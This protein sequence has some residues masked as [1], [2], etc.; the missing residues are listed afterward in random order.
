MNKFTKL[1]SYGQLIVVTVN[2]IEFSITSERLKRLNESLHPVRMR[3]WS[4]FTVAVILLRAQFIFFSDVPD[5]MLQTKICLNLIVRI[6]VEQRVSWPGY[7]H[8][9]E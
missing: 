5:K 6:C 1:K 8:R 4:V 9:G 2:I 7:A 3:K